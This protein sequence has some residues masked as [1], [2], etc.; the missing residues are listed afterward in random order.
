MLFPG[1]FAKQRAPDPH[2][3]AQDKGSSYKLCQY[4][5]GLLGADTEPEGDGGFV[6][7]PA[8]GASCVGQA[9]KVGPIAVEWRWQLLDLLVV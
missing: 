1:N 9:E 3:K 2:K 6:R 8:T 4:L 7:E 5:L